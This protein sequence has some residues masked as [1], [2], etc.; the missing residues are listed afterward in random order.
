M[1]CA[2]NT[3]G[4]QFDAANIQASVKT[5]ILEIRNLVGPFVEIVGRDVAHQIQPKL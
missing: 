1:R 5:V 2:L 3:V 4:E